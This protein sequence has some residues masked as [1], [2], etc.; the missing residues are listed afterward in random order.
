[1]KRIK[2]IFNRLSKIQKVILILLIFGVVLFISF[3]YPSLAKYKNRSTIILS[4]VWDGSV[5]TSYKSGNGTMGNPYIISS[6]P[7]LAYFSEQLLVK[8]YENSYFALSNDIKLNDGKFE[9]DETNGITYILDNVTYYVDEYT[10][11]YYSTS[12][13]EEPFVGVINTFN[14]LNGF[15]G[16]F[17]GDSYTIYGLYI[18]NNESR[19]LALFTD[20]KGN[21]NDLYIENSL[22]YGGF[23]TSLLASS[24]TS[25]TISNVVV[26]G[27]VVGNSTNSVI[28]ETSNINDLTFNLNNE[29][30]TDTILLTNNFATVGSVISNTYI[31]GSY[32]KTNDANVEVNINGR[33]I[34]DNTFNIELGTDI[35]NSIPITITSTDEVGISFT[36]ITYNV[37][38][39]QQI[40]GGVIGKSDSS[41]LNNV[42]NKSEVH[43]Y[44]VSGGL[45]GAAINDVNINNSYNIGNVNGENISGGIIGTIEKS[46][47]N[48]TISKVYNTGNITSLLNGNLI[49]SISNN[50]GIVTI[51]NAFSTNRA[52]ASIGNVTTSITN[53][54][55]TY[56]MSSDNVITTGTLSN[57]EFVLSNA[58][59]FNSKTF[60]TNNL[61]FNEYVDIEDYLINNSN[62]WIIKDGSLP[63]LFIDEVNN[64]IAK[65]YTNAYIWDNL[66][67][68]LNEITMNSNIVFSI[69]PNNNPSQIEQMSYYIHSSNEALTKEE[70]LAIDSWITYRDGTYISDEGSH[71]IYVKILDYDG[72]ITYLNTDVL[73]LDKVDITVSNNTWTS[74]KNIL[75]YVY[76]DKPEYVSI[77]YNENLID[78]LEVKYYITD[79]Y[80]NNEDLNNL[81]SNSWNNEQEVLISDEGTYVVYA[82]IT[83]KDGIDTYINS[84][85]IVFAG[86]SVNM[87]SN[88]KSNNITDKSNVVLNYTYQNEHSYIGNYTHNLM[89]NILLPIGT[90]ITLKDNI[91]KKIYEYKITTSDDIYNFNNSCNSDTC[92]KVATYPLTLFKEIGTNESYKYFIEDTYYSNGITNED[93]TF[94]IDFKDTNI[95]TNY[96]SVNI[97]MELHDSSGNRFIPTLN[98][99]LKTFNI[100]STVNNLSSTSE[101]SLTTTYNG[102]L[103]LNTPLVTKIPISMVIN[104]KEINGS[105][106]IDTTYQNKFLGIAIKVVD[107]NNNIVTRNDLNNISFRVGGIYYYPSNDSITY[108]N[109]S[110]NT[111]NIS[112]ELEVVVNS[113]NSNL[114]NGNY[115]LVIN[116]YASHKNNY[117]NSFTSDEI[118]IP[119]T[120]KKELL[121]SDYEFD[122][123]IN[124][125]PIISKNNAEENVNFDILTNGI[126]R[127]P[128]LR[129]SLYEK[130]E[131]TYT[132]QDYTLVDLNDY[133]TND[134]VMNTNSIYKVTD[135]IVLYD[136]TEETYNHFELDFITA[137]L[138]NTGYKFVFELYD[139][140]TLVG[141]IEKYVIVK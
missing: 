100:Y 17:T 66:S 21:I 115:S 126:F 73:V 78:V 10:N 13:K 14:S 125:G 95:N 75:D 122:V 65:I 34:T 16:N 91:T 48:T 62:V 83:N 117:S 103:S 50:S 99:T 80:L 32:T 42:I 23:T 86:Y 67:Y 20:L 15:K 74:S 105:S 131:L 76:I 39:E 47:N 49:G 43:G 57:G 41:T 97:Y 9:Y 85:Y 94:N 56:H 92:T 27:V 137:N 69:Q 93:F 101:L 96:E 3:S 89:S 12:L 108:I 19:E 113:S 36:N 63:T 4:S 45:I 26:D 112:E 135:D 127:N 84:D 107:E 102:S 31:T 70:L 123:K 140:N 118:I 106:I 59:E 51:Q 44:N 128:S 87:I 60:I 18:T 52:S 1:M 119:L 11:K 90:K 120:L 37:T 98:S 38:Y 53:A 28:T 25:S 5:A 141:L 109:L 82:K 33:T 134:L 55:K 81:P 111:S 79:R 29:S 61:L 104:Y 132:N 114:T 130:D 129:V 121:M 35:L 110:N 30:L 8:D 136:G 68:D 139:E 6:A 46:I 88:I 58:N 72:N 64:P 71:I 54:I 2:S 24:T 40:T 7:E 138:N 77:N 116:G 22:V 133:V 124:S